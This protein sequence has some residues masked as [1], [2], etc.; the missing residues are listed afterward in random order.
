[1]TI[2]DPMRSTSTG[3]TFDFHPAGGFTLT[4]VKTGAETNGE[5]VELEGVEDPANVGPPL[6]FHPD[7]EE[8][9]E[10]LYGMARLEI[11]G[12][13]H[14]LAVGDAKTVPPGSSHTIYNPTDEPNR[15]RIFMRPAFDFENQLRKFSSLVTSGRV[16]TLPPKD[17]RSRVHMAMLFHAYRKELVP[18]G[19]PP[20]LIGFY[21]FLGRR[22]GYS[23]D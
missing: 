13:L 12:V 7:Q 1:M 20:F 18:Q 9:F 3:E 14:D 8:T 15:I 17:F 4:V 10:V 2:D 19:L 5:Y 21:A 11:D 22:L 6:H 23:I 16:T